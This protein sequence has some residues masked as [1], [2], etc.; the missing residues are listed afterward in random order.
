MNVTKT[1]P[2]LHDGSVTSL[3]ELTNPAVLVVAGIYAYNIGLVWSQWLG[4]VIIVL[5]VTLLPIERR[6]V[7]AEAPTDLVPAAAS[8]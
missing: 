7:V 6:R 5:V 2:W 1:G 4:F 8:A 3:A